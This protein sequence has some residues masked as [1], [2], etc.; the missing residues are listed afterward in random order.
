[1]LLTAAHAM[2]RTITTYLE[3]HVTSAPVRLSLT[4]PHANFVP[5]AV[6]H[7]QVLL[8]VILVTTV[9]TTISQGLLV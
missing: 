4:E 3:Q 9:M 1:M 7:A 6:Q 5:L 8:I 2:L